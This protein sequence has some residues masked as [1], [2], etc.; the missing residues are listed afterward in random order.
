[1]GQVQSGGALSKCAPANNPCRQAYID[2]D[3]GNSRVSWD[4]LN[5]LFAVRGAAAS[6]CK[7]CTNCNG[8]N[9]VDSGTGNNQWVPG[10]ATN[11]SFLVLTN[12]QAAG[13]AI[14]KLLCQPPKLRANQIVG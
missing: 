4:P 3:G 5:T 11:Q 14:D 1:M 12:A 7:E 13:D 6:S 10:T 8:A 9:K 2:Y